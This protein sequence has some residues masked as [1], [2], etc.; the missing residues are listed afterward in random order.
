M[1]PVTTARSCAVRATAVTGCSTTSRSGSG[2]SSSP[3]PSTSGTALIDA[4]YGR[5][6]QWKGRTLRLRAESRGYRYELVPPIP[7]D[8]LPGRTVRSKPAPPRFPT[9]PPRPPALAPAPLIPQT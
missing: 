6:I 9:A 5:L 8:V 7:I 4:R 3:T 2:R 1:A